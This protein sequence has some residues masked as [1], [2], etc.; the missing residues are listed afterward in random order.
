MKTLTYQKA[1]IDFIITFT[2]G[3]ALIVEANCLFKTGD[4]YYNEKDKKAD[5]LN[6]GYKDSIIKFNGGYVLVGGKKIN[7]IK[8]DDEVIKQ[9][10]EEWIADAQKEREDNQ[11]D[12]EQHRPAPYIDKEKYILYSI[13]CD[14]GL[15]YSEK[16]RPII[17]LALKNGATST[18][19]LRGE[20][21]ETNK[22]PGQMDAHI[23]VS[24]ANKVNDKWEAPGYKYV[25]E[26]LYCIPVEDY[27]VAKAII[28]AGVNTKK[29]QS[30]KTLQEAFEKARTTGEPVLISKI[31]V[32]EEKSPLAAD[33][34]GDMV[35]ICKF[36]MPD[37]TNQEKC[38]HNY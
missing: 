22:Y 23:D 4:T 16:I 2:M 33:G 5:K 36:A 38:F 8:I 15:I 31:V 26:D 6:A 21:D 32:P 18:P 28:D 9:Q 14:T 1:G 12:R 20:R 17:E 34:E 30:D 7:G 29:E 37:G 19:V 24:Y 27:N 25:Y 11:A 35:D 10:I 13:G 3:T